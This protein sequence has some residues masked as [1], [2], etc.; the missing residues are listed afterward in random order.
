MTSKDRADPREGSTPAGEG[1]GK[2]WV[3]APKAYLA[4]GAFVRTVIDVT[5][6]ARPEALIGIDLT[7]KWNHGPRE[8]LSILIDPEIAEEL[9]R[10]LIE[11]ARVAP[12]DLEQF[13]RDEPGGGKTDG[14]P[15]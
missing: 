10:Y 13:V 5:S 3:A 15:L 11:G 14:K 6:H 1:F 8:D 12:E 7:G 4:E 9:G 2:A